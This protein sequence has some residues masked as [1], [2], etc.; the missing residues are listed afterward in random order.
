MLLGVEASLKLVQHRLEIVREDAQQGIS[1]SLRLLSKS[2]AVKRC[3]LPSSR[4][5]SNLRGKQ[6][7]TVGMIELENRRFAF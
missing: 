3:L 5:E 4:G 2:R 1:L 6:S 7:E